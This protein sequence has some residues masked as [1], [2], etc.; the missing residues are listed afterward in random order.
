MFVTF[1]ADAQVDEAADVAPLADEGTRPGRVCES[2][3]QRRRDVV[4]T[5]GRNGIVRARGCGMTLQQR[6]RNWLGINTLLVQSSALAP[7]TLVASV[8]QKTRERHAEVLERLAKIEAK[9]LIQHVGCRENTE[10]SGLGR[11]SG[12][13]PAEMLANPKGWRGPI[14]AQR[15]NPSFGSGGKTVTKQQ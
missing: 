4:R 3:A 15:F 10:P 13:E 11:R 12:Y 1:H 14:L 5:S 7:K 8:E 9:L 2:P 6:V